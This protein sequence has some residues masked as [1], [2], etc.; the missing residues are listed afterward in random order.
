MDVDLGAFRHPS[1][2]TAVGTVVAYS[3]VLAAMFV[4]LFVV[5]TVLFVVLV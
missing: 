5:P 4:L 1:W 2:S 3:L